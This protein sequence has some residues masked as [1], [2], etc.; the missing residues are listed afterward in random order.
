MPPSDNVTCRRSCLQALTLTLTLTPGEAVKGKFDSVNVALWDSHAGCYRLFSRYLDESAGADK[1]VRA[2]QSCISDDFIHWSE[3]VPHHYDDDV[4]LEHFYTNA[5]APCP[6]AEHI[7]LSF[8][9]RFVPERT[10]YNEGM[11]YPGDGISDAVFMSSR[12]GIHWDRTF[13]ESWLRAGPDQ[14]TPAQP[15]SHPARP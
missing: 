15:R 8:P 9:M 3:P 4:P 7:L 10:K 2:I 1:G 13:M 11:D 12:D 5:T 14:R 6:G